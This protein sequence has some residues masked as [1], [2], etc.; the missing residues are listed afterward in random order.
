MSDIE[1]L[2]FEAAS[3][4][5]DFIKDDMVVGLGSGS[6]ATYAI[7][8]LAKKVASGLKILAIPTSEQS[9][10]LAQKHGIQLTTFA[11]NPVIDV[12]IDGADQVEL[13]SLDLVKGLGNALLGEKIVARASKKLIIMVDEHKLVDCLGNKTPLPLEVVP[14]GWELTQQ[15]VAQHGCNAE[16]KLD[17]TNKEVIT[18]S[19]HY[20]LNCQFPKIENARKLDK[21]LKLITGVVETGLF[22][23]MTDIVI[24]AKQSGIVMLQR[25]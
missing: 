10:A 6:T 8:V 12:T 24:V 4:A 13:I 14:F 5:I 7:E 25:Q 21:D 23:N 15:I 9:G 18:D 22:V 19:G 3:A 11:K 17:S 20:I 2:K 16:I 1:K